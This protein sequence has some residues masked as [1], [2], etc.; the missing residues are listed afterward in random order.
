MLQSLEESAAEILKCE[1][2]KKTAIS[3]ITSTK[4][5][6]DKLNSGKFT[7]GGLFKNDSEKKTSA[8]IKSAF[9]TQLE[10]DVVN[11]DVIKKILTVYVNMIAI[12]MYKKKGTQRYVKAMGQMCTAEQ[13]NAGALSDTWLSFKQ[14]IDTHRI[15]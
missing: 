13:H 3:D 14:M 7:F 15:K 5:E 9:I 6:I 4:A 1:V 2:D 8:I 10:G 11:Y 12:P